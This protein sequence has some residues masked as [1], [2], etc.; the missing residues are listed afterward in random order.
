LY[1]NGRFYPNDKGSCHTEDN[2]IVQQVRGGVPLSKDVIDNIFYHFLTDQYVQANTGGPSGI[3]VHSNG[4][5]TDGDGYYMAGHQA[6]T[7]FYYSTQLKTGAVNWGVIRD[8]YA[9]ATRQYSNGAFG[10]EYGYLGWPV[11]NVTALNGG[12]FQHFQHGSI[13]WNPKFGAYVVQGSVLDAWAKQGWEKGGLGY[14]I[15]DFISTNSGGGNSK[16]TLTNVDEHGGYQKFEGGM[17]KYNGLINS[18]EIVLNSELYK[19]NARQLIT[20]GGAGAGHGTGQPPP[21][22]GSTGIRPAPGV[23]QSINPQPLPP[24]VN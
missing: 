11:T 4:N 23:S 12:L 16:T 9:A 14:P 24:K 15:S 7:F 18:T 6:N 2:Y 19:Q 20:A 17:I 8:K 13:Y 10:A 3:L 5:K 22:S 21:K 1:D